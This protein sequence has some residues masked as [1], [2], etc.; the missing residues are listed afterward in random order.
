MLKTSPNLSLYMLVNVMLIKKHMLQKYQNLSKS[1]HTPPQILFF[2]GFF[3]NQKGPK[4]SFQ[5]TF[6]K[7][8]FHKMFSYQK[9]HRLAKI[10]YQTVVTLQVIQYNVFP[11]SWLG[12]SWRHGIWI[13]EK[14][15][16]DYLKN[17]KSFWSEI[18][19]I[20]HCFTS[21]LL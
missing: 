19:N 14:L 10:H 5:A 8:F 18:K 11:V 1:A 9:L 4:T 13:S 20:F 16:L 7:E 12:I 21:V 17:K 2:R 3:E 15:K 6:F